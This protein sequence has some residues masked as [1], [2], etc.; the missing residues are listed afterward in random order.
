M[1]FFGRS[2]DA[3][4]SFAKSIADLRDDS[5]EDR[6]KIGAILDDYTDDRDRLIAIGE[7]AFSNGRLRTS[8]L[9]M[10]KA[11]TKFPGDQRALVI[12]ARAGRRAFDWTTAAE[13]AEAFLKIKPSQEEF[14]DIA[15]QARMRLKDWPAAVAHLR[16]LCQINP[17]SL[18]AALMLAR[19]L[20]CLEQWSAVIP[21]AESALQNAPGDEAALTLLLRALVKTGEAADTGPHW[22]SLARVN[23]NTVIRWLRILENQDEFAFAT[24]AVL[25]LLAGCGTTYKTAEER[26]RFVGRMLRRAEDAKKSGNHPLALKAF[27]AVATVDPTLDQAKAELLAARKVVKLPIRKPSGRAAA[28]APPPKPAQPDRRTD[29][30]AEA[31]LATVRTSGESRDFAAVASAYRGL[32]ML[33]ANNAGHRTGFLKALAEAN[34]P[35]LAIKEWK[36]LDSTG[37]TQD[38]AKS[39]IERWRKRA[40]NDAAARQ[41]SGDIIGA[42]T[43]ITALLELL[44]VDDQIR[45]RAEQIAAAAFGAAREAFRAADYEQAIHLLGET[46]HPRRAV[47]AHRILARSYWSLGNHRRSLEHWEALAKLDA[48]NAAVWLFISR[49]CRAL[50]LP[51][52]GLQAAQRGLEL[53]PSRKELL[54]HVELY[55]RQLDE[56]T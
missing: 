38:L 1:R 7:Y 8:I 6:E 10:T 37:N 25:G 5:E 13:A 34:D 39:E 33:E 55:T 17:E 36:A 20:G 50:H 46:P 14:L 43:A 42:Q 9:A 19:S 16:A 40:L 41:K 27:E 2:S 30:G 12:L 47:D 11:Q 18:P 49:C 15:G 28:A 21:V 48:D 56:P 24:Q 23:P 54:D 32:L 52:R 22:T 53:E 35:V 31:L 3:V 44:P 4:V 45:R 26:N 29:N 51:E